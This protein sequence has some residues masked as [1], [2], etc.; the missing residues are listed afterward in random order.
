MIVTEIEHGLTLAAATEGYVRTPGVHMSL[1]YGAY[2][3]ATDPKRYG[4]HLFSNSPQEF[5]T[6]KMEMGTSF[7]EILEPKLI[8]RLIIAQEKGW[9]PGEYTTRHAEDCV[10]RSEPVIDGIC[11][12]CGAGVIYSPDFLIMNGELTLGEFK[13]TWYSSR[14]APFEDKFAKWICQIALYCYHLDITKARLYALFVN[15]A[16]KPPTPKLRAWA[17]EFTRFEL[18]R[19]WL[20]ILRFAQREG[21]LVGKE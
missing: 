1:L 2:F 18:E 17:I 7:E 14:N 16:Y 19:E 8:E 12:P 13:C 5:D 11:C 20:K 15:D 6:T 3:V 9:R 10:R 21:L 4:K